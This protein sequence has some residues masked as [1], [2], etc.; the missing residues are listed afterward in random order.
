[1][2]RSCQHEEEYNLNNKFSEG[3]HRQTGI[4]GVGDMEILT[5]GL[6]ATRK[7]YTHHATFVR[8]PAEF[9]AFDLRPLRHSCSAKEKDNSSS[10]MSVRK[11]WVIS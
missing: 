8:E 11:K 2:Q 7:G 4:K 3:Q 1:M 9:Q 10:R 6:I 5:F